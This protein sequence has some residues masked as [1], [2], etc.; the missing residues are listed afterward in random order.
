MIDC[1]RITY[2]FDILNYIIIP[3]KKE[4]DIN[5]TQ[6]SGFPRTCPRM[7]AGTPGS[8]SGNPSGR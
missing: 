8:S 5:L 7:P 2:I 3:I 6:Q 1:V 4:L